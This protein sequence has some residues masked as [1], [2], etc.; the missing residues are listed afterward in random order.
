MVAAEVLQEGGATPR[1]QQAVGSSEAEDPEKAM[2][3]AVGAAAS[4]QKQLHTKSRVHPALF[5]LSV[6]A[7]AIVSYSS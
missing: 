6:A 5:L 4:A 7:W 1:S 3:A 2:S